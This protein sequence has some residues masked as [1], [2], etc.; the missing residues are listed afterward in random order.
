MSG[1]ENGNQQSIE[2]LCEEMARLQNAGLHRSQ[3]L[4]K[5]IQDD[6]DIIVSCHTKDY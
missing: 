1:G 4:F 5:E 3:C 2:H 6:N